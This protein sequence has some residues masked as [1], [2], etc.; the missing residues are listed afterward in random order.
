[1]LVE[2]TPGGAIRT[3]INV[4]AVATVCGALLL[5][6]C[7]AQDRRHASGPTH[8]SRDVT[9][10]PA[11]GASAGLRLGAVRAFAGGTLRVRAVPS[12]Q[13]SGRTGLVVLVLETCSDATFRARDS[14]F[15]SA[16]VEWT[17]RDRSGDVY[18]ETSRTRVGRA[19]PSYRAVEAGPM[20]VGTCTTSRVRFETAPG[21]RPRSVTGVLAG[22]PPA[23]WRL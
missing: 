21:A 7:G 10:T 2:R 18:G 1:M 16:S 19:R 20:R 4:M 15:T 22:S 14:F 12:A 23:T 5:C 13:R 6:S 17:L 3:H 11:A 9:R 8:T